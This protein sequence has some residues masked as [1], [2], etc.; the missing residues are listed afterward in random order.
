MSWNALPIE[1]QE[2]IIKLATFP[3][4]DGHLWLHRCPCGKEYLMNTSKALGR[5]H[6]CRMAAL[7]S[8]AARSHGTGACISLHVREDRPGSAGSPHSRVAIA[9]IAANIAINPWFRKGA[10]KH[11]AVHLR[12]RQPE[13]N[14]RHGREASTSHSLASLAKQTKFTKKT[15]QEVTMGV[16]EHMQPILS[17]LE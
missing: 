17:P 1:L 6:E 14:R 10:N 9:V 15:L 7:K 16:L 11:C 2:M 13:W 5:C 4:R 12:V 8:A 3:R